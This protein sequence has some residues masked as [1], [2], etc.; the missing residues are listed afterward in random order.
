MRKIYLHKRFDSFINQGEK[1][2]V[3]VHINKTVVLFAIA[4]LIVGISYIGA[5]AKIPFLLESK[6][7]IPE[8]RV[9][10][11]MTIL[12]FSG[13]VLGFIFGPILKRLGN[14][15]Y[16]L[17]L[18]CMSLGNFFF[19][20]PQN[21]VLFYI[22]AI[23]IGLSFVGTMSFTFYYVAEHVPHT[24]INFA[25]SLLLALGNVGSILVPLIL[26]KWISS[27]TNNIF[28]ALFYV[29]T[30]APLTCALIALIIF[31]KQSK[32]Q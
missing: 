13:V 32:N 5:T 21:M 7:H 24:G 2:K 14:F 15:T 16:P 8:A 25:T 22:G 28:V 23:L 26:T 4:T 1:A 19:L 18:A 12:A 20:L 31:S 10:N 6:Y 9:T 30:I 3:E 27:F 11:L 29:T 17:M